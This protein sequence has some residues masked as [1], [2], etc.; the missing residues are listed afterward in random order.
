MDLAE[1]STAELAV[2]D[3]LETRMLMR[4]LDALRASGV[5]PL[6]FKGPPS[7]GP[8]TRT[9]GRARARMPMC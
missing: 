3:V 8:P 9:P 6:L 1:V 2:Y 5:N 4:A 7:H